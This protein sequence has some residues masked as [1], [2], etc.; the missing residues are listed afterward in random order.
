[1]A[2]NKKSLI[3]ET[4]ATAV[5]WMKKI[6]AAFV[7]MM[8]G[9]YPLYYEDKYFNMGEAKWNFFRHISLFAVALFAACFIWYMVC[10]AIDEKLV[11]FWKNVK[12]SV[13]D[14]I[15]LGYFTV[16][17]L[18]TIVSPYR[19]NII[20]GY[21]GWY[22]GYIAQS[23]FVLIYLIV[24]RYWK[25]DSLAMLFYM[26][27]AVI[28]FFFAIIMRF[29]VDPMEMYL[30]LDEMYIKNFISTIGQATWYSSYMVVIFPFSF[31]C[32]W[33]SE[34]KWQRILYG[35]FSSI[36][37]MTYVTQNSDSAF[38]SFS[39]MMLIVLWISMESNRKFMRF[40]ECMIIAFGSF[41]FIGICQ[42]I[43]KDVMVPING[44]SI[45]MS[46]GI[47]SKA[48]LVI[49]IALYIGFSKLIK[50]K[51]EFEVSRYKFIR[52]IAVAAAVLGFAALVTY[53]VLNTKGLLPESISSKNDML[54]FDEFWGNNRGSSWA[55]AVDSFIQTDIVKKLIGA[56][57]DCFS[58]LVYT[59][60]AEELYLKWGEG[61]ILTCSH[62]EW[63]NAII[64]AGL[65][66]GA[67]YIGI[68][69]SM[70]KRCMKNAM[71]KP[72]LYAVCIAIGCYMAHNFFCYQQII[73]TPTIFIVMGIGESLIRYGYG[74]EE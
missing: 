17:T 55:I 34:V 35:I 67:L 41:V 30:N 64:N 68:F 48:V 18:T 47:L 44:P 49:S 9:I 14:C 58:S 53:I 45:F 8:L 66:G 31:I 36:G 54:Y 2:K 23:A 74:E 28:V 4:G 25:W 11:G 51:P 3:P 21:D 62:N 42:V 32:Y 12:L 24:S 52:V 27:I 19:D 16:V 5:F 7:F 26:S 73:C 6:V 39:V 65:I 60:H 56:G 57:P 50:N 37:F 22:M 70:F 33:K 46:Q 71:A 63:L 61:T 43:F 13:T 69:I 29:R 15:V 72:E 59:Y 10:L 1:M 38:V 40:L 20:F